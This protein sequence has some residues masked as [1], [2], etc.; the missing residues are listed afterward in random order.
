MLEPR[1]EQAVQIFPYGSPNE[2]LLKTVIGLFNTLFPYMEFFIELALYDAAHNRFWTTIYV[3]EKGREKSWPFMTP[4][5]QG[6]TLFGTPE[7]FAL[8]IRKLKAKAAMQNSAAKE[9]KEN[10]MKKHTDGSPVKEVA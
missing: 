7:E 3:R 4:A 9:R 8:Q 1:E 6:I 10:N 5:E 2:Q